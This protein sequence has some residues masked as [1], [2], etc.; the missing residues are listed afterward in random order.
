MPQR[1]S[2]KSCSRPQTS[3]AAQAPTTLPQTSELDEPIVNSEAAGPTGTPLPDWVSGITGTPRHA[4]PR[5]SR[6]FWAAS[7]C[8]SL[9]AI[10]RAVA[11][12]SSAEVIWP[13]A[14]VPR[15]TGP[16]NR[17]DGR[18]IPRYNRQGGQQRFQRGQQ[19]EGGYQRGPRQDG[20]VWGLP[21]VPGQSGQAGSY[22]N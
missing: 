14:Q 12:A 1:S 10:A 21:G 17:P 5:K 13:T 7:L 20:G 16:D 22:A 15:G 8:T 6:L 4:L 3:L 2:R 18:P 9:V 19:G 11:V